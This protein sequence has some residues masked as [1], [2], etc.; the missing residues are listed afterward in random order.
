MHRQRRAS[1]RHGLIRLHGRAHIIWLAPL[2]AALA[3]CAPQPTP[4]D[5][6]QAEA[7]CAADATA[8][9]RPRGEVSVGLGTGFGGGTRSYGAVSLDIPASAVFPRD[10]Q[11]VFA[12]C[13]QARSGQPPRTPLVQ[14]PGWVP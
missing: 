4:I 9:R 12:R 3:G 1:G 10:P 7:L 14:Q 2:I 11:A 5:V 6:A 13:V 8:A